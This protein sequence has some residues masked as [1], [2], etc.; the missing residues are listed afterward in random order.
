AILVAFRLWSGRAAAPETGPSERRA[1]VA[2]APIE[3]GPITLRR[4]FTGALEAW[5]SFTVAPKVAGRIKE[6]TVDI[7]DPVE[8]G[9]IVA[10]LDDAEYVQDVAQAAA[11]L[12][13]AQAMLAEAASL[14]EVATREIERLDGLRTSGFATES[15][16]ETAEAE[17]L[18][19]VAQVKVAEAQIT[20]AEAALASARIRLGYTSI[21]A[22][23]I[24]TSDRRV[25][26][27][28]FLDEGDTVSASTPILGVVDIDRMI[29]VIHVTERDYSQLHEKQEA[30]LVTDA[31]PGETF[32]GSIA[33]I[34]PVFQDETRQ[35]RVEVLVPNKDRRLKPGMFVR[36]SLVLD[37]KDDTTTVPEAA[38]TRREG[39][40]GVFV[41]DEAGETVRW[42]PVG[43]GLTDGERVEVFGEGLTGRVVVLGQQ[44]VDDGSAITIPETNGALPAQ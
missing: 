31:F 7:S 20:R 8:R 6:I 16:Y 32:S 10:R 3:R 30:T 13:V 23:W 44:L 38:L 19:R 28:R 17:R 34:A 40:E 1:P 12:T 36:V 37:H 27:E 39:K 33:R 9:Q 26:S 2:V 18:A 24:E 14:A 5:S 35:A 42:V 4:T 41:V 22:D 15:A 43:T 25:V 21:G 11:D 29:A